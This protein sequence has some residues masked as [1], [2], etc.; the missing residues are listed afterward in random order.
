MLRAPQA[1]LSRAFSRRDSGSQRS[2]S[3]TV[4]RGGLSFTTAIALVSELGTS[5]SAAP[6]NTS[7][8]TSLANVDVTF[9][10]L[11][12]GVTLGFTLNGL[13]DAIVTGLAAVAMNVS[14]NNLGG[15]AITALAADQVLSATD[16]G[17]PDSIPIA[18]LQVRSG[19]KRFPEI[20]ETV[21]GT[22]MYQSPH[23]VVTLS[24]PPLELSKCPKATPVH[25]R[26]TQMGQ[27]GIAG[28][29]RPIVRPIRISV[30]GADP[31]GR[32]AITS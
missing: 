23:T 4:A 26:S 12:S 17:D 15:Y 10:I 11:L 3:E 22:A 2:T 20:F 30:I 16:A 27:G 14:T 18:A 6:G 1:C 25:C 21:R 9:S 32:L 28:L 29:C 8:D 19:S 24:P 13:P 31:V 5:A 7:D